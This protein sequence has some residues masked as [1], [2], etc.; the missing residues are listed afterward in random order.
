MLYP[1]CCWLP[2][3]RP[4]FTIIPIIERVSSAAVKPLIKTSRKFARN[5]LCVLNGMVSLPSAGDRIF[6]LA[7]PS[8]GFRIQV[9]L[10]N[11][12]LIDD[13]ID[14]NASRVDHSSPK[15]NT[16]ACSSFGPLDYPSASMEGSSEACCINI[17]S[18]D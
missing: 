9:W 3:L 4:S 12:R 15:E 5:G 7:G 8:Q 11:L 14:W 2:V 6:A 13:Y 10:S 18:S 17:T 16:A 1:R